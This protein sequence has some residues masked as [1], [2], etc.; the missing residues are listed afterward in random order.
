M[1][2]EITIQLPLVII[3]F[4][5]VVFLIFPFQRFRLHS[6][7]HSLEPT[8]TRP[9][10]SHSHTQGVDWNRLG[11]QTTEF[12]L[13]LL[14]EE[15][16]ILLHHRFLLHLT[17]TTPRKYHDALFR[18][19]NA[20]NLVEVT[21][22]GELHKLDDSA[23][24]SPFRVGGEKEKMLYFTKVATSGVAKQGA[25]LTKAEEL[26]KRTTS[27]KSAENRRDTQN[28]R[29]GRESRS[30]YDDDDVELDY[31]DVAEGVSEIVG[32]L[33]SNIFGFGVS[34]EQSQSSSAETSAASKK[35]TTNPPQSRKASQ[36]TPT[37]G[38]S[39]PSTE[40]SEMDWAVKLEREAMEER[41]REKKAKKEARMRA[42]EESR[43]R[44]REE[45]ERE[46]SIRRERERQAMERSRR[47]K[48][49]EEQLER[50]RLEKKRK[51]KAELAEK[52]EKF[53]QEERRRNA[54]NPWLGE[55]AHDTSSD[56]DLDMEEE[57]EEREKEKEKMG[58]GFY[59]SYEANSKVMKR[60][61][62]LKIQVCFVYILFILNLKVLFICILFDINL[63]MLGLF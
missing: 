53:A 63:V 27:D 5:F 32:S 17:D 14:F 21:P 36:S 20:Y 35:S 28:R 61:L 54:L 58:M 13:P 23:P 51:A 2:S 25:E 40:M 19:L 33:M 42:V 50:E 9:L 7:F 34:S 11:L 49:I 3:K 57:E 4:F 24:L 43:E 22:R 41:E 8:R 30:T 56:E 62:L 60:E 16:A 6:N 52:Y 15:T 55:S 38:K 29:G 39:V 44:D 59:G 26:R 47:L 45:R 1:S 18:K 48:E 46:E 12:T 31:N 37:K 10:V